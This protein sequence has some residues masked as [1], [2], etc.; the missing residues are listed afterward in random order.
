MLFLKSH[1][2]KEEIITYGLKKIRQYRKRKELQKQNLGH[3]KWY[4]F[5][6][7]LIKTVS[8]ITVKVIGN[9]HIILQKEEANVNY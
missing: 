2:D 1:K 6:T 8:W 3:G 5:Y 4:A 9:S 7:M